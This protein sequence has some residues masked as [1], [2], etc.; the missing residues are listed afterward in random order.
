MEFVT[1]LLWSANWK[2]DNYDLIL[3]IV[4]WL[5]KIVH[6][7]PVKVTIDALGLAKVIINIVVQYHGVPNSIISDQGA[8]FTS[9]FWFLLYY[10]LGIKQQLST[11]FPPPT[12]R[13]TE[14]QNSTV[15]VYFYAFVNLEQNDRAQLLPMAEFAYNN[16]KNA[17]MGHMPFK[18]NCGYHL[19]VFFQGKYD[20]RSRSSS[21]ET[22][23]IEL[24]ELM[25]VYCQ[26][27]LHAQDFQKRAYDKGIKLRSYIP[28]E[29]IWL[30]SKHIKTKR[31]KKLETK[32]FGPFQ[33][34]HLVEK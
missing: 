2:N 32:F 23:A 27:L 15:K 31:N 5:T 18:L 33:V 14:W 20:T 22:M 4:N 12:N 28:G 10:F 8:I 1:G 34:L 29:K 13:Q 16:F 21:E 30:N 19:C 26:N 9:K 24:R 6:D 3:V 25:N 11:M 7:K 17:S